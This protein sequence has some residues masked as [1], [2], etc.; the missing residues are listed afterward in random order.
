MGVILWHFH[1][2]GNLHSARLLLKRADTGS[3]REVAHALRIFGLRLSQPMALSGFSLAS[4]SK[5]SLAEIV[6]ELSWED[7]VGRLEGSL[8]SLFVNVELKKELKASEIAT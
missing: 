5:V 4:V 2:A 3:Q 7:G 8:K 1:T 6:I